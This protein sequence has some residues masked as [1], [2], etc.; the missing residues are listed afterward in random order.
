M[1][2]QPPAF[3]NQ[4]NAVPRWRKTP[5]ALFPPILG[6]FGLAAA[7]LRTPDAFGAPAGFG[8]LL[9]G[10]MVLVYLFTAGHYVAKLAA[11]PGVVAE[12]LKTLP[13]R[14]GPHGADDRP[15][16][17]GWLPLFAVFASPMRN[18][19]I[20]PGRTTCLIRSPRSPAGCVSGM[21]FPSADV[22][23]D[24]WN[25]RANRTFRNRA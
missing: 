10:A 18:G 5:P 23:D 22:Q 17:A 15:R 4:A 3:T 16:G 12:D 25:R 9:S 13:G 11:R 20:R 24:R 19:N 8:Q 21:C 14:A 7:W 1:S 6:L 2:K